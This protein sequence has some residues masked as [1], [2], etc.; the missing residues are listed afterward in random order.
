MTTPGGRDR[1]WLTRGYFNASPWG[2]TI[3][4]LV[5]ETEV[6]FYSTA[7]PK[8]TMGG[9]AGG[10]PGEPYLV[11]MCHVEIEE[12][13][14]N[15]GQI[16]AAGATGGSTSNIN[17]RHY[18]V[19]LPFDRIVGNTPIP[20]KNDRVHFTD[21]LGKVVD[22][23]ITLTPESPVNARDHIEIQTEEFD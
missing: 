4:P 1:S 3:A 20:Q 23:P 21:A 13:T 6:S 7:R 9:F 2:R 17:R 22:M 8:N 11:A 12:S 15:P 19:L 18:I 5:A 10:A 14:A 16:L